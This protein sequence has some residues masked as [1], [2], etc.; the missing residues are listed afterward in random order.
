MSLTALLAAAAVAA[1]GALWWR[2][3]RRR[4]RP[5]R[6]RPRPGPQVAP[7]PIELVDLKAE[8]QRRVES[9]R[10]C[11]LRVLEVASEGDWLRLVV[12]V[13]PPSPETR[14]WPSGVSVECPAQLALRD[15]ATQGPPLQGA[16]PKRLEGCALD[17]W[18]QGPAQVVLRVLT[19]TECVRL[20]I[21]YYGLPAAEYTLSLS[22]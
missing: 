10:G 6:G 11:R 17:D 20:E 3:P 16:L 1:T 15:A 13:E 8:S 7:R 12:R 4:G 21:G 2:R 14:W 18:R 22:G 9:M 5:R 19:P